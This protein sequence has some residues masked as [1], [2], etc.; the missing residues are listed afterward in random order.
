MRLAVVRR[1]C[2]FG[3]GGAEAYCANVCRGLSS[4]GHDITVVA[5]MSGVDCASFLRASVMGRGSLMKNMSFF[6][7]SRRI[8][9]KGGFDLT[10]GLSRV[11]PVDVLRISDPLHAAWLELG[12]PDAGRLRRYMP[13]HRMLLCLEKRAIKAAGMIVV[14]SNLVKGQ[15]ERYYDAASDKIHVIYNG[16]DTVCFTP[17]S[18]DDRCKARLS[19][20]IS[21][22]TRVFLFAG[23]DLRRKGLTPLL[24]GLEGLPAHHD[25]MLLIAGAD[26]G[27]DMETEIRRL[28]L[29]R[30]VRWL[31]YTTDMAGLYGIADIFML[32]TLYDPFANTVLEAMACG[33]P[34]LTTMTNGA[35]EVAGE[36]ADW[37]VIKHAAAD[38][39]HGALKRFLELS[40][41]VAAHLREKA[42]SIARRYTWK[43]HV[44]SL[45]TLFLEEVSCL[46]KQKGGGLRP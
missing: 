14:N 26:G 11:A 32:P 36:V 19:L 30:R 13:R 38:E 23:S 3:Y 29:E 6:I 12:Y 39:I 22:E 35:S 24:H 37:L 4:L 45:Q 44:A 15:I 25:F 33:A 2:G 8:L 5:D 9:K 16:V 34:V 31:G 7:N 1:E 40:G 20:G 28:G 17:M 10:Y 27:N 43:A 46:A 18:S 42:A 41:G 21:A